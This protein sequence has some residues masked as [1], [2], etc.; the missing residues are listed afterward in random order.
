MP[1][2]EKIWFDKIIPYQ[3]DIHLAGKDSKILSMGFGFAKSK[4]LN[5]NNTVDLTIN[6]LSYVPGLRYNLLSVTCLMERGCKI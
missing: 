2:G 4:I 5:D 1:Y 6:D 3:K